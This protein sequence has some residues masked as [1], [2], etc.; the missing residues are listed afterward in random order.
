MIC[1]HCETGYLDIEPPD[2]DVGVGPSAGCDRCGWVGPVPP[3]M[4]KD[5]DR[6]YEAARDETRTSQGV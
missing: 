5:S 6:D 2:L 1:K 3:E 4:L